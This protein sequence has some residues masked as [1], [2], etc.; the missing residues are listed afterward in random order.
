VRQERVG[1]HGRIRLLRRHRRLPAW[2]R[3]ALSVLLAVAWIPLIAQATSAATSTVVS[4]NFDNNAANQYYLGFQDALQPAGVDATFYI[5]SGTL[6]T[7][8]K[9]SW[10]QVSSL[11]AAGDDIG[12][13]TVDGTNLT[14]LTA[15]QQVSEICTDRQNILSHGITPIAFAYPSG[16]SNSAIQAEVQGCG[17]GNAR[18]AGS[19]SPT[20]ATYAETLPPRSWLALRAYAPAG[21]VTLSNLESLVS[22]AASH[23]GGWAPI[24]IQR[25]CSATLD[26]ANY[27][28]CTASAGWIDLGDLQTFISWVQNAGQS[29]DAPAGTVFQTMGATATGAD[30]TAPATTISCNGAPCQSSAYSGT[31]AVTLAAADLGS[32][33]ASTH[34]T[35]DG[36]TPTQASPTY[37]GQFPLTATTTVEYRSWDYTGNAEAAHSQTVTVQEPADSTPPVTTIS[38]NGGSC[39]SGP[40]YKPV[41]VTLSATDNPGGWGVDKTYYTTDGSTPT[42]SSSV[43]TGPF[44]VHGPVT[45]NFFSTDLAGNAEQVN[46]QQVNV[47]T[48]ITL[49]FD[50][51]YEDQWLYSVPL[52][53][54]HNFTGTYYVITSDSD[55]GFTCCMSWSQLDTLQA[56]GNDIG[57][58]TIDHPDNLTILTTA[59]ITQEVCG[60]RQDLISHGI[61]DPQS[62]A[63]PNGVYNSTVESIVQQCG[64]NNAR[65]G[66]GI[67][68]S[69]TTPTA[70]YVETIPPANPYVLRT[71][72][73]DGSADE[74]LAD[75]QSFVSAASAH[76]GGWLPITFHDVCDANASDFSDCMS[77]YGSVQDTVFGQFL[78]WLA[79]AGQPGGAPAGV[80]VKNVC[81]VMNCP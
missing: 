38:C 75:L 11:A 66:G 80:V 15:P 62:F 19:L 63:Y 43:Y 4:L 68:N 24:V 20:G 23:G 50:D 79:A 35:L 21:Q 48:V 81:Q 30:T 6:G 69:N 55:N 27:S 33:V 5:N 10:S 28:S 60:S 2:G 53:Q 57:S 46:T 44:T 76:G 31:V 18:T 3:T 14:T 78:N 41:T 70:P 74:N 54:A 13:K 65:G 77:K 12:G 51:Q 52:M 1:S 34:Y 9:L 37:T 56:Q 7:S 45:V 26:A 36:T 64:F 67:S 73:V 59:Q 72:A 71:I 40:Y 17:Y 8:N 22:G 49:T 58:H 32:G 39:Q 16:A 47:Q 25:V 42:T 29:G 61:T